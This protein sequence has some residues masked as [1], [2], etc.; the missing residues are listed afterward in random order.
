MRSSYDA[1]GPLFDEDTGTWHLFE[2]DGGWGH[3]T[4]RDLVHFSRT[5]NTTNFSSDT[6]SVTPTE[7]GIYAHWPVVTSSGRSCCALI[8]SAVATDGS[9]TSWRHRTA[10]TIR[11]PARI[12]RGFRDPTRAFTW[13]GRWYLGVGCDSRF[14]RR[15]ATRLKPRSEGGS[16]RLVLIRLVGHAP[17]SM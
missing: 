5:E 15:L 1:S 9:L 3:W 11:R 4:S 6:G 7:T 13:E 14:A 8:D 10:P 2:D 16:Q 17:L 12:D